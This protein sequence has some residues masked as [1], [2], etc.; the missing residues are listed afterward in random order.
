MRPQ[1]GKLMAK[2]KYSTVKTFLFSEDAPQ[3]GKLMSLVM[4]KVDTEVNLLLF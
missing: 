4:A 3:S 2:V 1:T